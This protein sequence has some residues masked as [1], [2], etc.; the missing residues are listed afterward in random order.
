MF[1]PPPVHALG[2][3]ILLQLRAWQVFKSQNLDSGNNF[4]HMDVVSTV[5]GLLCYQLQTS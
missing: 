5:Y 3:L 2:P 4:L 1:P